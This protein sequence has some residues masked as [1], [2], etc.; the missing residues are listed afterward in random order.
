MNPDHKP[1]PDIDFP[2]DPRFVKWG[3]ALDKMFKRWIRENGWP[4]TSPINLPAPEP[5]ANDD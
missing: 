2:I 5:K 3:E 1:Y 4:G